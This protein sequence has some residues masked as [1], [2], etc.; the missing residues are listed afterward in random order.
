MLVPYQPRPPPTALVPYQP[1]PPPTALVPYEPT[2]ALVPHTN[3]HQ[4]ERLAIMPSD[5]SSRRS[6]RS[7]RERRLVPV[8]EDESYQS[9]HWENETTTT[10]TMSVLPPS[11]RLEP[12]E[13]RL[14]IKSSDTHTSRSQQ[15]RSKP[16]QIA[17]A[18]AQ[19]PRKKIVT[20]SVVRTTKSVRTA[21]N[22]NSARS[23]RTARKPG[24]DP[25]EVKSRDRPLALPAPREEEPLQICADTV[26]IGTDPGEP[27]QICADPRAFQY[28]THTDWDI[29]SDE[30]SCPSYATEP[31]DKEF[32]FH[33]ASRKSGGVS[34]EEEELSSEEESSSDEETDSGF[35]YGYGRSKTFTL[36]LI[37]I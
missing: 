5:E 24:I 18:P 30:E 14:R 8:D 33:S 25:P 31:P 2:T 26:S 34:S 35:L 17:A 11:G 7:R 28:H 9:C 16:L 6:R 23:V 29:E 19:R 20:K 13:E 37:H 32:S 22:V 4:S 15:S 36:S 12:P 1:G 27:L 21:K 3:Q 10:E